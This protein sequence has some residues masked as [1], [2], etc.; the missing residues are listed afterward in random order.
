MTR[1]DRLTVLSTE[2]SNTKPCDG[3]PSF[4]EACR[5]TFGA[6][7]RAQSDTNQTKHKQRRNVCEWADRLSCI[8]A[9]G[10]TERQLL[11]SEVIAKSQRSP[12]LRVKRQQILM[13][14]HADRFQTQA[15]I[16]TAAWAPKPL[17][18]GERGSSSVSDARLPCRKRT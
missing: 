13:L 9:I 14:R 5:S 10:T 17:K 11:P 8:E 4:P 15:A 3:C 1:A 12:N 6:S 18:D 2:H 16:C 7:E